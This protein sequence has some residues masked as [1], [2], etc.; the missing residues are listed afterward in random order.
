MKL[1]N[2]NFNEPYLAY[3]DA[4]LKHFRLLSDGKDESAEIEQV[5]EEMSRLWERLDHLQRRSLSGIGSDL[6]WVRRGGQLPPLGRRSAE[7]SQLD[8]S[9]LHAVQAAGEWHSVLGHLRE[10][11][12]IT[13]KAT[14]AAVRAQ[15]YRRLG[16]DAIAEVF[17]DFAA[18]AQT[19][20]TGQWPKSEVLT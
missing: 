14:L 1:D 20:N 19:N 3:A 11:A 16:L 4:L 6:N 10:R 13:P 12:A 2:P 17:D 8:E 5:E 18:E 15:C 7:V 9:E